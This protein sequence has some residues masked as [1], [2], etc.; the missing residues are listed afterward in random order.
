[1]HLFASPAPCK[2]TPSPSPTYAPLLP[3]TLI[4]TKSKPDTV[5]KNL[6]L[7]QLNQVKK[8]ALIILE[9]A[10]DA[11]PIILKKLNEA[12][13]IIMKKVKK[14]ALILLALFIFFIP[15]IMLCLLAGAVPQA[16]N[17]R[18]VK[19]PDWPVARSEEPLCNPWHVGVILWTIFNSGAV[20]FWCR[21][22]ENTKELAPENNNKVGEQGKQTETT[23][24]EIV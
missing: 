14:M 13:L 19:L 9:K 7:S 1:M 5:T 11:A 10:K 20:F 22:K 4:S 18:S 2:S 16:C 23:T 3:S 17:C 15:W 21:Q 12:A 8:K 24:H 6:G